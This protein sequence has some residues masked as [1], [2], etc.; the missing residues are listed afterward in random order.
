[1]LYNLQ[2]VLGD[3]LFLDA[4]KH[5]FN[6]WKIAHPYSED[7]RNSIIQYRLTGSTG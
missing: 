4:M 5:Y 3:K 2:Y 6:T 7:F 1:M